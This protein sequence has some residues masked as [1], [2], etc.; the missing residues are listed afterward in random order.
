MV[1]DMEKKVVHE[2]QRQ[3]VLEEKQKT[4]QREISKLKD[5]IRAYEGQR[6]EEISQ[7]KGRYIHV[8]RQ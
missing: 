3:S 6:S 7:L 5:I 8:G 4:S 2:G 1:A